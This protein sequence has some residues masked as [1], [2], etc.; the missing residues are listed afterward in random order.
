MAVLDATDAVFETEVPIVI[1]GAGAAGLTAALAARDAGAECLILERDATPSGSTALSSGMIPA[2]GT[3]F[4]AARGVADSVEC[5]AADIQHK[6]QG[7]ADPVIVE[8]VTRAAGPAV[9][10]LADGHGV[11]LALV[12]GFLYPGH[13]VARMHA[14]PSK[15]GADLM[16][17]L[18]RAV[19]RLEIPIVTGAHVTDLHAEPSG[20]VTGVRFARPDG[21]SESV[22]CG[23][24][25]LACNGFGG[26]PA[27][28]RRHIPEIADALYAGHA[29]NQGDAVRWG[30]ALGA[31]L[32]HMTAYQGH[33]SVAAPHGMLITW[34]LMMAGGIQVNLEGRRFSDEHQG[35]SEQAV[36][37][38][39]QPEGLAWNIYD[40]P[41]HR[42]GLDFEDYRGAVE[43]GAIREAPDIAAL[44]RVCRLPADALHET[45]GQVEAFAA[46]RRPD[47]FGRDFTT[48]PLLAPPY[49]AVRVTGALFHT[50][51]GLKVDGHA[52]VL[53]DDGGR[54]PNLLAAG[55][56]ACGVSGPDVS[57][58]LS[59]N[60]LLTAVAL[61]R[62]AGQTAAAQDT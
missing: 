40:E 12:E 2:A 51:G 9:D 21:N 50:Q 11:P 41:L 62:I 54:L 29:G 53:R 43:T 4:Q 25:I 30:Q 58:Y 37:V 28:V 22:G 10:W 20:R 59:G 8:A 57:G 31:A 17:G 42:L 47:P 33:G 18:V 1:V 19:E 32:Q 34:A 27:M 24:L 7:R 6:A 35:Y 16:A 39:R 5:F 36:A 52:R 61:G 26:N 15:T 45:L 48:E 23:A 55:G 46:G 13:G 3:R 49:Y 60:G 56:A 14:P 44:A 38:L